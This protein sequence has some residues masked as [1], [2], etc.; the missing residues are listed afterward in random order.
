MCCPS[1]AADKTRT[2]VR[3]GAGAAGDEKANRLAVRERRTQRLDAHG[4]AGGNDE[5]YQD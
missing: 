1:A 4:R 2:D 3:G 5:D